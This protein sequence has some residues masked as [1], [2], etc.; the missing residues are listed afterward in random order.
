MVNHHWRFKRRF[1]NSWQKRLY[2]LVLETEV[3]R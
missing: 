1:G 2:V 3:E